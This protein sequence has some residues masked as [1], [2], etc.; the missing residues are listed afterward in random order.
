M[1]V[2]PVSQACSPYFAEAVAVGDAGLRV[3]RCD[4]G[5]CVKAG[6]AAGR[7]RYLDEAFELAVGRPPDR[8]DVRALLELLDRELTAE[9]DLT[10]RTVARTVELGARGG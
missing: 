7:S 9:R 8:R 10:G 5:W 6:A 4:W 1:A 3:Y 2:D